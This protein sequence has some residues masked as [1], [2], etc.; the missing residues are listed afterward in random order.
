MPEA[1]HEVVVVTGASAGIGRAAVQQFARAGA[2]IALI[3]RDPER[4][5]AARA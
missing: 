3:A 1:R 4:L 2:R 5:E